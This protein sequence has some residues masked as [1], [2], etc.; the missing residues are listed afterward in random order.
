VTAIIYLSA[1]LA[2]IPVHYFFGRKELVDARYSKWG[3]QILA[4]KR[5]CTRGKHLRLVETKN[6]YARRLK[7][8]GKAT[9]TSWDILFYLSFYAAGAHGFICAQPSPEAEGN[10]GEH[11]ANISIGASLE[12]RRI[13]SL[14]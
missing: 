2:L 4:E 3:R 5:E 11:I 14:S 10:L 6:E 13:V 9:T 12:L 1:A 7:L 8:L